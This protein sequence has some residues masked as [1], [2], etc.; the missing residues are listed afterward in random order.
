MR[1]AFGVKLLS[2]L[3]TVAL[4]ALPLQAQNETKNDDW[5]GPLP[6]ENE[7]PLQSLFLHFSAENPDVLP[8]GAKRL[9]LQLDIANNLLIPTPGPMVKASPKISRH[10]A[11][12]FRGGAAW[13]AI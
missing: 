4:C 1:Y 7:R 3:F 11:S 10:S 13:D 9:G 6:V 12:K 8:R 5:Q 2:F